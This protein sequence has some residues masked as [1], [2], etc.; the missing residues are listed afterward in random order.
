MFHKSFSSDVYEQVPD[1][2]YEKVFGDVDLLWANF[3]CHRAAKP[4]VILW[5]TCALLNQCTHEGNSY[6]PLD[7]M[8]KKN[9]LMSPALY[10]LPALDLWKKQLMNHPDVVGNPKEYKPLL[11]Y[12]SRLYLH[13]MHAYETTLTAFIK[14]LSTRSMD[15]SVMNEA[16]SFVRSLGGGRLPRTKDRSLLGTDPILNGARR[17]TWHR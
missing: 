1:L 14:D 3:I 15:R 6:L 7:V 11:L 13:R 9:L 17:W 4:S 12:G 10:P 16:K 2:K 5:I 8:A